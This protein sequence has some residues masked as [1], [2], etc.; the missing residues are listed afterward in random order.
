M[1][2]PTRSNSI[3]ADL[4]AE[5]TAARLDWIHAREHVAA[6]DTRTNRDAVDV[7]AD[8]IDAVLDMY[9]ELGLDCE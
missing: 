1:S 6:K 3:Q 5:F 4:V 9:L 2:A 8:E 7:A